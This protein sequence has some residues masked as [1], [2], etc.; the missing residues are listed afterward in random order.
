MSSRLA[1]LLVFVVLAVLHQ[2][3]WNWADP[4]PWFGVLP[5][6]LGYHTL[7]SVAAAAFGGLVVRFA[8]PEDPFADAPEDRA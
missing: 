3:W 2:D 6:G 7:Y 4:T 5:A 1:V 8:W